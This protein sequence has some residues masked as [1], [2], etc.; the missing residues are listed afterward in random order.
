MVLVKDKQT[1][2]RR[3]SAYGRNMT[4]TGH[5]S[6][7][8]HLWTDQQIMAMTGSKQARVLQDAPPDQRRRVRKLLRRK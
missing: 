6:D 5:T 2:E 7:Q 3:G 8:G 1:P 4:V